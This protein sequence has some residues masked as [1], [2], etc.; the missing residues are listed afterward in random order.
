MLFNIEAQEPTNMRIPC[1]E[2][3]KV[4]STLQNMEVDFSFDENIISPRIGC[5][6]LRKVL[7]LF[8]RLVAEM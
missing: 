1:C 5:V 3:D 7:D 4:N 6:N 2:N 8:E